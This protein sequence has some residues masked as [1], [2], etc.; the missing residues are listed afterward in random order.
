M[1]PSN[2]AMYVGLNISSELDTDHGED[3][4]DKLRFAD[5]QLDDKICLKFSEDKYDNLL[6][7][8][9]PENNIINESKT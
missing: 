6:S 8:C 5:Q 1:T 2:T 4:M 7:P 9:D 3:I